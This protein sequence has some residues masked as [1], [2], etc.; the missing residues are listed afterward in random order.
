MATPYTSVTVTDYNLNPPPDD[1]TQAPA[2]ALTWAKHKQKI[3]DPLKTAVEAVN[4]NVVAAV[5]KLVG[6]AGITSTAISYTVLA[7][8]Q[9]K[10]IKVT[11]SGVTITTP[12]AATVTSP[13]LFA[14]LNTSGG[15]ITIDGNGSETIDGSATITLE[16][17]RGVIIQTDGT[18]WFTWGQN[19]QFDEPDRPVNLFNGSWAV[20]VG[21]NA[22]TIAL[23]NRAGDDP[24]AT[25]SVLVAFRSGTVTDD[26]Y[27]V[28]EVT[29]ALSL[30]IPATGTLGFIADEQNLIHFGL[31]DVGDGTVAI[32]ASK[33]GAAW[34]EDRL[35]SSTLVDT[36]SDSATTIYS[37]AA[38][39]TQPCRL[40]GNMLI[41]TGPTAG[42]WD[43]APS[44]VT[45]V[46]FNPYQPF[47]NTNK[48]WV[49]YDNDGTLTVGDAFNISS[50]ADT[51]VGIAT[52]NFAVSMARAFYGMGGLHR[53]N[54][55]EENFL[56]IDPGTA[57]TAS[58]LVLNTETEAG[59][60]LDCPLVSAMVS[61]A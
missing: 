27:V 39:T 7:S 10:L 3:G 5:A 9:S 43:E 49:N 42:N 35:I 12:A 40:L 57:P 32:G 53:Y 41:A 22:L 24:S 50:V 37:T 60:Q 21:S 15:N 1:G 61:G 11:G 17:T 19:W 29:A 25:G 51:G 46:N 8:D 52:V 54:S 55:G 45:P 4:T 26:G 38:H 47:K 36:A 33:D 23:K 34:T 31:I 56:A 44:R 2:N 28:R 16:D 6:G 18:N 59:T 13:F 20:S 30:V 48:A 14:V 58:A